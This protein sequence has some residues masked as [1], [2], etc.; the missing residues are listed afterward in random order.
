[1]IKAPNGAEVPVIATS[2]ETVQDIKQV[3]SETAETVEYS[4]FYLEYQGQRLDDSTELSE[5]DLEPESQFELF[6]DEYTEREA[7]LHVTRLRD[8]LLG[9]VTASA[10]VAGLDAGAPIFDTIKHPD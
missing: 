9:T 10:D 3:V 7:R 5:L 8:L 2:Q 6:E 4:C 1:M